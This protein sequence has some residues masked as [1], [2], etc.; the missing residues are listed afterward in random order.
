MEAAAIVGLVASCSSLLVA[1]AKSSA[2]IPIFVRS[3]REA[4]KELADTSRQ[5]AELDI[6]LRLIKDDLEPLSGHYGFLQLPDSL[7]TEVPSII[8]NCGVVIGE[9]EGILGEYGTALGT[10][11]GAKWVLSGRERAAGLNR[12]LD[13]HVRCLSLALDFIKLSTTKSIKDDTQLLVKGNVVLMDHAALL[14]DIRDQ[15]RQLREQVEDLPAR[16]EGGGY[17]QRL[18][19]QRWIDEAAT[20]YESSV[21][22][23]SVLEGDRRSFSGESTGSKEGKTW[24]EEEVEPVAPPKSSQPTALDIPDQYLQQG[25]EEEETANVEEVRLAECNELPKVEEKRPSVEEPKKEPRQT[26]KPERSKPWP[27]FLAR[28]RQITR[29]KGSSPKDSGLTESTQQSQSGSVNDL[30]LDESEQ[31]TQ[32][33]QA[34]SALEEKGPDPREVD[35]TVVIRQPLPRYVHVSPIIDEKDI[36]ADAKVEVLSQPPQSQERLQVSPPGNI[37]SLRAIRTFKTDYYYSGDFDVSLDGQLLAYVHPWNQVVVQETSND[38]GVLRITTPSVAETVKI[39]PNG[40]VL[41][42]QDRWSIPKLYDIKSGARFSCG[43]ELAGKAVGKFAISPDGRLLAVFSWRSR[44]SD[45]R[46]DT[47]LAENNASLSMWAIHYDHLTLSL[48]TDYRLAEIESNQMREIASIG[49]S[50]DSKKVILIRRGVPGVWN[51]A[52]VQE[53]QRWNWCPVNISLTKSF[54]AIAQPSV[55]SAV[56]YIHQADAQGPAALQTAEDTDLVIWKEGHII[57]RRDITGQVVQT[58]NPGWIFTEEY[59]LAPDE[60]GPSYFD[61]SLVVLWVSDSGLLIAA[62]S[63]EILSEEGKERCGKDHLSIWNTTTRKRVF[64]P[65]EL[66]KRT[67]GDVNAGRYPRFEARGNLLVF[68]HA[69]SLLGWEFDQY[70]R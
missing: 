53:I 31:Q 33:S 54:E 55:S 38:Q 42:L 20:Y 6:I 3:C 49:F 1:V 45:E 35:T 50:H 61:H 29:R 18:V 37:D 51:L 56:S 40:R 66:E 5:L 34:V 19:V 47:P 22:G 69:K 39:T 62:L 17:Q 2:A 14:P 52:S 24:V 43:A 30:N 68:H 28:Y 12:Q 13:T 4:R 60:R 46:G 7:A 21:A 27:K 26:K 10:R 36:W 16:F 65:Q 64:G 44:G 25:E 63:S 11:A 70:L 58:L 57:E 59:G 48:E 23:G 32:S 67:G 9:F 41:V 8:A 15:I